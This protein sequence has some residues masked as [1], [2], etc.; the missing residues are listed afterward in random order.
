[1]KNKLVP[2][3]GIVLVLLA[4]FGSSSRQTRQPPVAQTPA[5]S[6]YKTLEELQG[7]IE[8]VYDQANPGCYAFRYD[9]LIAVLDIWGDMTRRSVV[10]SAVTNDELFEAWET[11][12]QNLAG[13]AEEVQRW[14]DNGGHPEVTVMVNFVNRD[15]HADIYASASRG[16]ILYDAVAE[17]R[18]QG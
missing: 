3:I 8:R 5:A 2:I 4:A 15:N 12:V 9:D 6:S 7:K 14:F 18:A 13:N 11:N 10:E 1:M 16:Q 17:R